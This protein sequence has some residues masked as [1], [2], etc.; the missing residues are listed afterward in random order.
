MDNDKESEAGSNSSRGSENP[1]KPKVQKRL[2]KKKFKEDDKRRK[3][4]GARIEKDKSTKQ[5]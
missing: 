2:D 5:D 4:G 3:K 1:R